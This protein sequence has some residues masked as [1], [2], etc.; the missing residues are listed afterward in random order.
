MDDTAEPDYNRIDDLTS[1]FWQRDS[2]SYLE[3]N[4][5]MDWWIKWTEF[6]LK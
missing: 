4:K 2:S 6:G 1:W 3:R 5:L